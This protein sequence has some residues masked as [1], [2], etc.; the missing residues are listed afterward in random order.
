MTDANAI[1]ANYIAAWNETDAGRRK[2]I[3]ARTFATDAAYVDPLMKGD[4]HDG[5]DAL[6]AGV[7]ARFPGFRFALI[8]KP[9]AH[10]EHV[11]FSWG[12]G[13]D[14]ADGQAKLLRLPM[15]ISLSL[16]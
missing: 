12:L 6:I 8:G 5:V 2:A 7:H 1:A 15:M 14:G 13:P 10:G 4:G 16:F 11:R 3:I 9:D